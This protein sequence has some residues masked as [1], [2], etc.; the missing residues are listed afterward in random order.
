MLDID[1]SCSKHR[2]GKS[3]SI[4]QHRCTDAPRM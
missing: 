4:R 2:D 1:S 3:I